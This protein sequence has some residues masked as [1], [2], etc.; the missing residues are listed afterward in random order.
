MDNRPYRIV[1]AT[2]HTVWWMALAV[3]V[4]TGLGFLKERITPLQT[5]Q[6]VGGDAHMRAQ[7]QRLLEEEKGRNLLNLSLSDLSDR[8]EYL[9]GVNRAQISRHL[10]AGRLRVVL[11][12]HQPLA[13]WSDGGMISILGEWYDGGVADNRLPLF[14]GKRSRTMEM[15]EFYDDA[16]RILGG[17]GVISQ[18]EGVA[19]GG[20]RIFLRDGVVLRLGTRQPRQ[21]LALYARHSRAL[22][23]HFA[24]LQAVDL[25]YE[26]GFSVVYGE[27]ETQE[28]TKG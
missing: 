11:H 14:K 24:G 10:L 21:K 8:L 7:A 9:P 3:L 20:W 13:R 15:A 4:A 17:R 12:P 25:R 2:S 1:N 16:N 5:V 22:R 23:H 26:K 19:T 6:L 27:A 18:L 28:E